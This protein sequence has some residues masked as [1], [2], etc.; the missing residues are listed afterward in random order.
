VLL[1]IGSG[2]TIASELVDVPK[3]PKVSPP[4]PKS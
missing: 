3:P 1:F 4:V 2:V